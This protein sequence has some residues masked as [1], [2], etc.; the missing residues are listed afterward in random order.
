MHGPI[1]AEL[2]RLRE[3]SA[4]VEVE[5]NRLSGEIPATLG[6]HP[7]TW[8][9]LNLEGNDLARRDP[10][11]VQRTLVVETDSDSATIACSGEIPAWF[12]NLKQLRVLDLSHN[13]FSGAIPAQLA[14]ASNLTGAKRLSENQLTGHIPAELGQTLSS[15]LYLALD[16]NQLHGA[17]PAALGNLTQ[18]SRLDPRT[19][20]APETTFL[21][22]LGRLLNL[23]TV[24]P[25]GQRPDRLPADDLARSPP[26]RPPRSW[27]AVL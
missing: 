25:R 21:R 8:V 22:Q 15:K 24:K 3:V 17:I 12:G 18:L 23:D 16:S 6:H 10:A 26:T 13:Q 11:N 9:Y 1:P 27:S 7:R 19:Q 14:T 20:P 5:R 2:G 4:Y